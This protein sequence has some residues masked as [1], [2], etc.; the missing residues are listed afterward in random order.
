MT[1]VIN[2]FSLQALIWL[3]CNLVRLLLASLGKRLKSC[4]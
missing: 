4:D 1:I 3:A 2:A